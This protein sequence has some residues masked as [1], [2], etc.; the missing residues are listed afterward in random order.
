MICID[1]N[2][3]EPRDPTITGHQPDLNRG[4]INTKDKTKL[5]LTGDE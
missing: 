2:L 5:Q 1:G 4:T 3:P